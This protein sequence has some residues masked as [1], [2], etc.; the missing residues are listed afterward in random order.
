MND[1]NPKKTKCL[2]EMRRAIYRGQGQGETEENGD[3]DDGDP[4]VAA[5]ENVDVIDSMIYQVKPSG[6]DSLMVVC[7]SGGCALQETKNQWVLLTQYA[8]WEDEDLGS[9]ACSW[10]SELS[11]PGEVESNLKINKTKAKLRW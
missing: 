4:V 6:M 8:W 11:Y 9:V 10:C 3:E 1:T 5:D 2:G 7:T